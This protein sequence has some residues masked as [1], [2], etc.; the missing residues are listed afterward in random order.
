[1]SKPGP[2]IMDH[3]RLKALVDELDYDTSN[4]VFDAGFEINDRF[5]IQSRRQPMLGPAVEPNKD[6]VLAGI[7]RV[8][9]TLR[10]LQKEMS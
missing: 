10:A 4:L 1:M 6:E 7:K 5:G 9:K 8:R 2:R 3:A